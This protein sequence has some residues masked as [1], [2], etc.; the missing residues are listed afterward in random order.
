MRVLISHAR[1]LTKDMK[2]VTIRPR[3]AASLKPYGLSVGDWKKMYEA[4]GG[5]CAI[6]GKGGRYKQLSVDHD[7]EVQRNTGVILVLGL[8][9]QRCNRAKG[10]FEWDTEVMR[11]AMN[12]L[13][14][15]IERREKALN[16]WNIPYEKE[17]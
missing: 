12:Y 11:R 6:C 1:I 16:Q 15:N 10:A 17:D 5:R 13:R 14:R 8:L 9:C 4:Q 7:H 3:S 2:V